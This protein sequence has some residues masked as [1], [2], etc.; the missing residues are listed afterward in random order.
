MYCLVLSGYSF[1]LIALIL[2]TEVGRYLSRG[3]NNYFTDMNTCDVTVVCL[4]RG[5]YVSPHIDRLF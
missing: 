3:P 2:M 4:T 5:D 1:I